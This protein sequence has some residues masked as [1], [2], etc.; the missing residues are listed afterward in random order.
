VSPFKCA[1][2]HMRA[3]SHAAARPAGARSNATPR[4]RHISIAA[5]CT[6]RRYAR[7]IKLPTR[8]NSTASPTKAARVRVCGGGGGGVPAPASPAMPPRGARAAARARA[9]RG[10]DASPQASPRPRGEA[11]I[12]SRAAASTR[13]NRGTARTAD[14]QQP[15]CTHHAPHKRSL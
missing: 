1:R 15:A 9:A 14:A 5:C 4:Q 11:A 2:A 7:P 12:W 6:G 13:A 3:P 8:Q 10:V